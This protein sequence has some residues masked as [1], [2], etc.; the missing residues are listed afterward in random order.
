MREHPDADAALSRASS[1]ARLR[2]RGKPLERRQT[3][4]VSRFGSSPGVAEIADR[5]LCR[6]QDCTCQISNAH[7]PASEVVEQHQGVE[8]QEKVEIDT[9]VITKGEPAVVE[10][11]T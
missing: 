10:P 6:Y 5:S 9:L 7:L 11:I 4:W 2:S 8:R 3:G 1:V